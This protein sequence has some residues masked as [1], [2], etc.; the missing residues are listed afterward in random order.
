MMYFYMCF[1]Q[2]MKFK[3]YIKYLLNRNKEKDGW[4]R[5]KSFPVGKYGRWQQRGIWNGKYQENEIIG[6]VVYD[7]YSYE[8]QMNYA[9]KSDSGDKFPIHGWGAKNPF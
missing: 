4:I 8:W 1:M 9:I 5:V 3:E 7:D 6:R 2:V